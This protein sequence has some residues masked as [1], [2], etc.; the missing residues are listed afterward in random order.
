MIVRRQL[1]PG[2]QIRQ[3]EVAAALGMSKSPVREALRALEMD[4]LVFHQPN[5]GYF[6]ARFSVADLRQI[7]TMRK[8]LETIIFR[9][10]PEF[11]TEELDQLRTINKA[12]DSAHAGGNIHA[13]VHEVIEL[14]RQFHFRIF[15]RSGLNLV[16]RE[17]ER[18]WQISDSYRSL[19]LYDSFGSRQGEIV[20]EHEAMI[21][22]LADH[23]LKRLIK[24]ADSQR[25][26]G[27]ERMLAM[28]GNVYPDP[29][30]VA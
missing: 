18:L 15:V 4:G 3:E 19:Y 9:A 13:N 26:I 16:V 30:G 25:S 8:A 7:Y 28:L 6:T 17:V 29:V 27:E 5:Q 21:D 1:Y 23:D 24:V 12:M 10:L 20:A 14:N 2:Q 22:A 11:P